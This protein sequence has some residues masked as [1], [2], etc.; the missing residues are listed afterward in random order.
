MPHGMPWHTEAQP[1]R[2]ID[3]HII[4]PFAVRK[5]HILL[6]S[7]AQHSVDAP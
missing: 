3:V 2:R 1:K 4:P 5:G 7:P 6:H